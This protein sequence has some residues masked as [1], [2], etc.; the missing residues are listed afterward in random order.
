MKLHTY[1]KD[2]RLHI[3]HRAT[4]LVAFIL[5]LFAL[6]ISKCTLQASDQ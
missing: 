1:I 3:V 4:T 6:D 5:E 2:Q